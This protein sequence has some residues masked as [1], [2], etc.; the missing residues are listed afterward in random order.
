MHKIKEKENLVFNHIFECS[1]FSL[2]L[3]IKSSTKHHKTLFVGKQVESFRNYTDFHKHFHK[4]RRKT[5]YDP[6]KY[7]PK[8]ISIIT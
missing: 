3:H 5:N 8:E 6:K 1:I 2:N 4:I 7:I